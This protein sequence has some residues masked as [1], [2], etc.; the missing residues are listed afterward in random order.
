M[1]DNLEGQ[2]QRPDAE[3]ANGAVQRLLF[4]SSFSPDCLSIRCNSIVSLGTHRS[5]LATALTDT[6]LGAFA[7]TD[8]PQTTASTD[9][10]LGAFGQT[11]NSEE[12]VQ[13]PDAEPANG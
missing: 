10:F 4:K 9:H 6:I 11:G 1:T 5:P 12:L 2:A 3:P 13:R 8:N 7:T